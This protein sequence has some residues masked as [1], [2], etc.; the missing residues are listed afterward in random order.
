MQP[1]FLPYLGYWQLIH[2][3]D[4]FV[5]Y[6]NIQFVKKGWIHRNRL[7][8]NGKPSMFTLPLAS[9]SDYLNVDERE[10]SSTFES[11]RDRLLRRFRG[12][13]RKA[14]Y[15]VETM[16]LVEHCL[17]CPDRNLFAFVYHSTRLVVAHLGIETAIRVSS[18]IEMDH[19]LRNEERVIATCL[20]LGATEYVNPPGGMELYESGAFSARGT[21]YRRRRT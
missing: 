1:Y 6:D 20:A 10:L 11:E 15:F 7:L 16:P 14:P 4:L 13:Y 21:W 2:E 12:A 3:C 18:T 8:Q 9:A 5:V 19:S 17:A